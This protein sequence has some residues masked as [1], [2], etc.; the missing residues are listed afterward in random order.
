MVRRFLPEHWS[1]KATERIK[2][3]R[4]SAGFTTSPEEGE[5]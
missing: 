5:R 1:F 4:E 2:K 3:L